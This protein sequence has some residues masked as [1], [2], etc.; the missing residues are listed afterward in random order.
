MLKV[1]LIFDAQFCGHE[2][3]E[4]NM[5]DN[6]TEEDIQSQ[7]KP[8]LGITYDENCFYEIMKD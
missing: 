4:V 2:E 3:V 7:F 6:A 5:P 8:V 1:K